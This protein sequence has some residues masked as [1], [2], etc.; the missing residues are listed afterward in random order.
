M[1]SAA[2]IFSMAASSMLNQKNGDTLFVCEGTIAVFRVTHG[3]ELLM[4]QFS[5]V[6]LP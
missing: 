5:L 4:I 3:L 1:F 2:I 6:A